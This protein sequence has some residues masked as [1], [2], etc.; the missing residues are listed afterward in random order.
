M[1]TKA[2]KAE[3]KVA[4]VVEELEIADDTFERLKECASIAHVADEKYGLV[5]EIDGANEPE[6][7]LQAQ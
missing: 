5:D 2:Q 7:R 1:N 6:R 4:H 3:Q